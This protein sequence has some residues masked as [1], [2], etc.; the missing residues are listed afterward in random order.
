MRLLLQNIHLIDPGSAH[1]GTKTDV[2]LTEHGIEKIEKAGALKPEAGIEILD[3][4]GSYASRGFCDLCVNTGD[5]GF[6]YREDLYSV[7]EAAAAGGYT[8]ICAAASNNPVTQTKSQVEYI[9]HKSK[10]TAVNILPVGAITEN[11]D[12][13]TPTEMYD[14]HHAG[15]VAFSDMPHSIKNSGVLLRALQYVQPFDGLVLSMP[16]DET[17]VADGQVNESDV[18]VKMG[19]KGI[20]NL[21][22][23]SLVHRDIELLKYTG[24]RI[25]LAGISCRE[26]VELVRKAK[27]ENLD[28]TCSAFVH[29]LISDENDVTGFDTNYKVFPPLRSKKDQRLLIDA[30]L[31]GTID[32]ISTQHTPLNIDSKNVEF[33]YADFGMTGLE[34][35]FGL[36]NKHLNGILSKERLVELLSF[37]P[38]KIIRYKNDNDLV[39]LNFDEEWE[40]TEG[41]VRSKS[42]NSPYLNTP[43][44]GRVKA[45]YS[46]GKFIHNHLHE[47]GSR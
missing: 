17:L 16:F 33:E 23:Y 44:L 21:S 3:Y 10:S 7:A 31:D 46:K 27:S 19:M 14:M 5:P 38:R 47:P 25:H 11:F 26:S 24:G 40:L 13:K 8:V 32:C 4:E 42:Y 28:V 15:A 22:E 12:G 1:N 43:L 2:L 34:T 6:E 36:L 20:S 35:A 45:V 37:N 18:S 39:I 30:L 41:D 9:L 29:H